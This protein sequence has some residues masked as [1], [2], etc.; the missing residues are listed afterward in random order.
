MRKAEVFLDN[1]FTK[2]RVLFIASLK[3][4][5]ACETSRSSPGLFNPTRKTGSPLTQSG[6]GLNCCNV[7]FENA[8]GGPIGLFAMITHC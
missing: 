4:D 2:Q 7:S 3:Q 5:A 6:L 8:L 1:N